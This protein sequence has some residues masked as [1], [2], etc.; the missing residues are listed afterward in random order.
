MKEYAYSV[1]IG[2][3]QPLHKNHV[4]LIE[5]AAEIAENVIIIVGSAY[6]ASNIKNP[7]S[8]ETRRK[9]IQD[10]FPEYA[11][12]PKGEPGHHTLE[13]TGRLKVEGVRDYFYSD[14]VWVSN[15][16][17]IVSKY[18]KEG[19]SIALV[20]SWKD[21]SSWY[22]K[23]FPQWDFVP[24]SDSTHLSATQ[25]R[26]VF[27]NV[28]PSEILV[29]MSVKARRRQNPRNIT[30]NW[31]GVAMVDPTVVEAQDKFLDRN[32]PEEVVEFLKAFRRTPEFARLA[33]EWHAVHEYRQSWASSPFPPVFVTADAVVTCSGH[34]LVVKR[35]FNP[36][37]GLYALPGGFIKNNEV[38]KNAALRELKEE[39]RIRV[40]RIIL[41]SSIVDTRVFDYPDRSLRGRTIT[42]AFH[43]KL[44]DGKLPEVA[45][46]DDA[47]GAFWMPLMDVSKLE[48]RFFEDHAHIINYFVNKG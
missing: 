43:L 31:E 13:W 17:A 20:G 26:D 9:L 48:D 36:G 3:F 29:R 23:M 38:I 45:G 30:K 22:L 40:D 1:V 28:I 47:E 46:G 7:F 41:E 27:F 35:G 32:V 16:Q 25:V 34:V 10:T 14:N 4:K 37:K 39:T 44:K 18:A 19:D 5:K 33:E 24:F 15:V 11:P 2:R 8:F 12:L 6:A 42:H 21:E